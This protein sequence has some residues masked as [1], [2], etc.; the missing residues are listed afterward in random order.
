M[1]DC[2]CEDKVHDKEGNPEPGELG[3]CS[4]QAQTQRTYD[5]TVIPLCFFCAEN[6]HM[7]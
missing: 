6:G 3:S 2:M 4:N 5:G 1:S 7:Q